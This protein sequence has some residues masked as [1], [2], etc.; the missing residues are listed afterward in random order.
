MFLGEF[1]CLVVFHILLC[2]DRRRPT[3]TVNPGQNFNPLLFFAPAMCDMT[4]TSIMYVGKCPRRSALSLPCVHLIVIAH[5]KQTFDL[6]GLIGP[7]VP[8]VDASGRVFMVMGI[9]RKMQTAVKTA[10]QSCELN[11]RYVR[12]RAVKLFS[13]LEVM[14]SSYDLFS[15]TRVMHCA[16]LR[17]T[18][19]EHKIVHQQQSKKKSRSVH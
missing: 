10:D 7:H 18:V 17:D 13:N 11:V 15:V 19:R 2:H 12:T 9:S 14:E 16:E 6:F 4:A 8:P 3:P 5:F 1:S